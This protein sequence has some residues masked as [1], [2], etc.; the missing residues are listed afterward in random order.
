MKY[1]GLVDKPLDLEEHEREGHLDDDL[2]NSHTPSELSPA[3]WWKDFP[4]QV[5][6]DLCQEPTMFNSLCK[7]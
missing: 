3:Q 7:A 4:H 5:G 1:L 6:W 2:K